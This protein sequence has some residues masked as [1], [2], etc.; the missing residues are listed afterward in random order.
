M[1]PTSYHYFPVTWPYLVAFFI[2]LIVSFVMVFVLRYAYTRMGVPTRYVLIVLLCSLIGSQINVPVA[3]LPPEKVVSDQIVSYHGIRIVIPEVENWP[4]T[5]IAVNIGGAFIPFCLS[6]YLMIKNRLYIASVVG[7][8]I[9]ALVV[10][11]LAE[12]VHGVGISVPVY[13][14]PIVSAIVAVCLA[15]RQAPPLAYIVGSLGTLIGADLTNLDKVQG[16]GAPIASIGGAGTFDGI[17]VTGILAVLLSPATAR[18]VERESR[19]IEQD[20]SEPMLMR[21]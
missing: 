2:L 3:Q 6:I 11:M 4:A 12:P 7:V 1:H 16:L 13:I 5:I 17:F 19:E 15:W 18:P 21:D 9:V 8:T 14:P 10:H 20:Q